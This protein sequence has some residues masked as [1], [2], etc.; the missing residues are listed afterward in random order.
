VT[1]A[2]ALVCL[3]LGTF[4][5]A[6]GTVGILRMPDVYTRMHVA[7]KSDTLGAGLWLLGLAIASGGGVTALK[8]ILLLAFL[9][10][11][12]PTAAHCMAR[13]AHRTGV[14]MVCGTASLDDG[15]S[16][17]SPRETSPVEGGVPGEEAAHRADGL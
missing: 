12:S 15:R 11:T 3:V 16:I 5:F 4:F 6:A 13:A 9:W 14:P 17:E 2:A 7:A 10:L 1:E 8:L